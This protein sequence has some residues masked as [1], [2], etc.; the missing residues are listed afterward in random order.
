MEKLAFF[1]ILFFF[2]VYVSKCTVM[3]KRKNLGR[4][5]WK[6]LNERA[7]E[8]ILSVEVDFNFI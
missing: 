8:K 4:C 7:F 6:K 3:E 1:C 5:L 2:L